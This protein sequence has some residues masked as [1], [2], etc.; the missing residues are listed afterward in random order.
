MASSSLRLRSRRGGALIESAFALL[1]FGILTAGIMEL[2]LT[3]FISNSISFAAQRAA[4]YAAVRGSA[5]GHA[6]TIA[7]VQATAVSYAA[8]LN[9]T[10]PDVTVSWTPNNNPG[11]TVEVTVSY[12]VRPMMLPVSSSVLTL[13]STARQSITQ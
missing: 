12:S 6:A 4:R 9:L 8:P 5:S 3:G 2:G 10:P 13:Q 11:G 7:D 1:V